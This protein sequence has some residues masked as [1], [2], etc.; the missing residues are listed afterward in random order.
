MHH[1]Q[2]RLLVRGADIVGLAGPASLHR[3]L[4]CS[5]VVR[6]V[7]PVA[8][9]LAIAVDRQRFSCESAANDKRDQLFRKLIRAVVVSTS[10]P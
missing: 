5:T 6:N 10:N 8:N 9:V 3:A 4:D 2:V 7:E 1:L